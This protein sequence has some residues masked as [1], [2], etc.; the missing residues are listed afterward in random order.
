VQ[1]RRVTA[2][3][4]APDA[5]GWADVG[6]EAVTLAPIPLDAQ[7]TEYIRTKWAERPYG[8]VDQVAVAGA[9]D[10][11]TAW[12]RLEWSATGTE[13]PREF[14]DAAALYSPLSSDAPAATIGA[15]GAS[16][17]LDLWQAGGDGAR[18]LAATG[19][20]RFRARSTGS[21]GAT[22]VGDGGR[23]A[24]VFARPFAEVGAG[25]RLGIAVWDGAGEERAGIGAATPDWLEMTVEA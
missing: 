17:V 14:P 10:G 12:V 23:W 13:G 22:A 5:P 19:P 3:L 9:H 16:V 11:A 7:P 6:S 8:A 20:G 2:D 4:G 24:V 1:L 25:G 15:E 18:A 21:V